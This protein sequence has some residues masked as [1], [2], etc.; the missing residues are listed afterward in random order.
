MSVLAAGS[1]RQ[2]ASQFACPMGTAGAERKIWDVVLIGSGMG[3][4]AAAATLARYGRSVLVLE[5]HTQVGGLTHT[6][7]RKQVRWGTGLHY[8]GWPTAYFNDFPVLWE[9]L[10]QGRA[11]WLRLPDE[12]DHYIHPNGSFVKQGTRERYRQD[13]LERFPSERPAI[14]RYFADMREILAQYLRFMPLQSVPHLAERC[15]LGWLMGRKFLHYDRLPLTQYMDQIGASQSLRDHLWFTWGNFGGVPGET[16]VG[17]YAVPMEHLMDG[18]WTMADSSRGVAEAFTATI[19]ACGGEVRRGAPVTGLVFRGGRVVGVQAG[20]QH[21][22]ARTV[23][24]GIGAPETYERLVPADR[25]PRHAARVMH[26]KPSCS[27][28]TLY[29]ALKREAIERFALT[30]VNYWVECEPGSLRTWWNDLRSPPSWFLFSLASRFQRDA[31]R[32]NLIPAEIFVGVQGNNFNQWQQTRVMKRGQEYAEFKQE[33]M[34]KTLVRVEQTW[35][36]F[37][38]YLEFAEGASPLTI[39]SYTG[40]VRGAAYGIAPVPGRYSER[41]LRVATGIPGL[42][43]TG[44]DVAAAGVIGAF[45]GGIAAAGAVLRT[46]PARALADGRLRQSP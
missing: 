34:H 21:I 4:L 44:Q 18:L 14:D 5:A 3:S 24:S 27:I 43:L 41:S 7:A 10:T 19:T 11:P 29:L 31:D 9:A 35:P 39:T 26:M 17:A 46:N 6:F 40:H 23:I 42:L 16:S 20:E 28:F 30:G 13:L 33:L 38:Q 15:G 2:N 45:Y 36:G 1:M 32:G 25:R 12:A 22:R 37:S 8:T